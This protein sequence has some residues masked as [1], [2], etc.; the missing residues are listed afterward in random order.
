MDFTDV[1]AARRMVR[2]Y[3]S[4]PV[5]AAAL[6]RVLS[7]GI[8]GP[9]AGNAQGVRLAVVEDGTTRAKIAAAA[10]EASFVSRGFEPWLSI[11]PVHIVVGV[12]V[13]AYEQRYAELDK[14]ESAAVEDDGEWPIP[15]WWIDAGAA[16]MAILLAAQNEGLA[17]GFLGGHACPE[18]AHI[19][20]FEPDVAFVG[21]VTV[22]HEA[23]VAQGSSAM[24]GRMP[25]S[26]G[27]R[28]IPPTS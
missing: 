23:T 21:I 3:K 18:V 2:S 20:D 9:S 13:S 25:L 17:A 8:S 26:K 15:W 4:D 27:V 7:A 24:R 12:D 16:L 6:E 5:D 10:D 14:E 28:R 19:V 11:A 22:G 1:L